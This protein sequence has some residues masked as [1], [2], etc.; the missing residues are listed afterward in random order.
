MERQHQQLL[1]LERAAAKVEKK[2]QANRSV[3]QRNHFEPLTHI[4]YAEWN[5][6]HQSSKHSGLRRTSSLPLTVD[7]DGADLPPPGMNNVVL[8]AAKPKSKD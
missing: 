5:A 1:K 6:M 7:I 4:G 3:P 8:V 2:K